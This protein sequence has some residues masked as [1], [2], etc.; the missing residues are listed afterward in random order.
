MNY[1]GAKGFCIAVFQ[2]LHHILD[3][4]VWKVYQA[5]KSNELRTQIL[6]R[7][8]NSTKL[9]FYK[10]CLMPSVTLYHYLYRIGTCH[11][12]ISG[13]PYPLQDKYQTVR[14]GSQVFQD[15]SLACL[16]M[17]GVLLY[18]FRLSCTIWFLL[19]VCHSFHLLFF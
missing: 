13:V 5:S 8:S 9:Y 19:H 10:P 6:N 12:F 17:L 15:L 16:L 4:R 2:V 1:I 7:L 3:W 14:Q 11:H 18:A